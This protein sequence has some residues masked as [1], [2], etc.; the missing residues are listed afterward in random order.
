MTEESEIRK[1]IRKVLLDN[2]S[3]GSVGIGRFGLEKYTEVTDYLV[4]ELVRVMSKYMASKYN[5][6]HVGLYSN[7]DGR[8]TKIVKPGDILEVKSVDSL[9]PGD[10]TLDYRHD[11]MKKEKK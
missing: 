1:K 5:G 8:P 3:T 4:S 11:L 6:M 2:L 9:Y 7:T 10:V